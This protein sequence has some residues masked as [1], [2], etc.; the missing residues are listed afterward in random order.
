MSCSTL[1]QLMVA[2]TSPLVEDFLM[3]DLWEGRGGHGFFVGFG[4]CG[5]SQEM[6]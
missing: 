4:G 1:P 3:D 5:P 6:E 2:L